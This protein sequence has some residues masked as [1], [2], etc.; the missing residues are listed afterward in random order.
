MSKPQRP[1]ALL[2]RVIRPA[3]TLFAI[4][5]ASLSL[6]QGSALAQQ[7]PLQKPAFEKDKSLKKLNLSAFVPQVGHSRSISDLAFSPDGKLLAS[8]SG[9]DDGLVKV[10]DTQT[11]ALL[12]TLAGEDYVSFSADSKWLATGNVGGPVLI[13]DVATGKVLH[14][15]KGSGPL[16]F[17]ADGKVLVTEG[18]GKDG[19]NGKLQLWSLP[20]FEAQPA[21]EGHKASWTSLSLSV[22][23]RF[24]ATGS[25]DET[26][27]VW[28]LKTKELARTFKAHAWVPQV[29]ALSPD[30]E[31]LAVSYSG[32][33][34][35]MI[36][37]WD[38]SASKVERTLKGHDKDITSMA[39]S[40]DGKRLAT[41]GLDKQLRFWDVE[42][43]EPT[44]QWPGGGI[45][46]YSPNGEGIAHGA[47]SILLSK[48]NMDGDDKR[49]ILEANDSSMFEVVFGPS[50]KTFITSDSVRTLDHWDASAGRLLKSVVI[51]NGT[52]DEP[53]GELILSPKG[54]M[55]ALRPFSGTTLQIFDASSAAILHTIEVPNASAVRNVSFAPN[56]AE[57]I[58][59]SVA[60]NDDELTQ[61]TWWD[62]QTKAALSKTNIE[63]YVRVQGFVDEG[64]NVALVSHGSA[65][66]AARLSIKVWERDSGL[67]KSVKVKDVP[68]YAGDVSFCQSAPYIALGDQDYTIKLFDRTKDAVITTLS[69]HD[70]LVNT[71]VCSKDGKLLVTSSWDEQIKLWSLPE[72]KLLMTI[73]DA[74]YKAQNISISEDGKQLIIAHKG[75]VRQLH[76]PTGHWRTFYRVGKEGWLGHDSRGRFDCVA[77]GC[78]LATYRDQKS[79]ALKRAEEDKTLSKG[80]KGLAPLK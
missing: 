13:W 27:K 24:A 66:G 29:V 26:I 47:Q 80:L 78:K 67:L 18:M 56:E 74:H 53:A 1:C 5:A 38:V 61:F 57:L 19:A 35:T 48:L 42:R 25:Y 2:S 45:V 62:L 49:V 59:E 73:D 15:L 36:E 76:I 11:G 6:G 3:L 68:P 69:K 44:L 58:I 32:E 55:A 72:G 70:E 52:K 30:A 34:K 65:S 63:G 28:D 54:T 50:A 12:H 64:K 9:L 33:K 60:A 51:P 21:I 39:F 7:A 20:S 8:A 79:A 10:W 23:G 17:S 75:W 31:R 46:R 16:A 37:L 71:I 40:P 22:D 77:Q 43:G 14:T 41:A 4:T